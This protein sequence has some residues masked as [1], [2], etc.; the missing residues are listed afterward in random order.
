[1]HF[2]VSFEGRRERVTLEFGKPMDMPALMR[3][4]AAKEGREDPHVRDA[5]EFRKLATKRWRYYLK[6]NEAA[7]SLAQLRRA[8][9][10]TEFGEVGFLLLARAQWHSHPPV[11]GCC[12]CRRSWC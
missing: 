5:M 2:T 11:L 8:I 10:S 1:M 6:G 7:I 9:H 3:W 12:F 4:R